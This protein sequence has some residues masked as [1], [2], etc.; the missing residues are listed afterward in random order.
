MKNRSLLIRT[1]LTAMAALMMTAM[2][3]TTCDN[4][5]GGGGGSN[6]GSLYNTYW[7]YKSDAEY[8]IAMF[9]TKKNRQGSLYDCVHITRYVFNDRYTYGFDSDGHFWAAYSVSGNTITI[10]DEGTATRSGDTIEVHRYSGERYTLKK[11]TNF[12][13]DSALQGTWYASYMGDMVTIANGTIDR[14]HDQED[15]VTGNVIGTYR[16]TT[17]CWTTSWGGFFIMPDY[18]DLQSH[19]EGGLYRVDNDGFSMDSYNF[20]KNKP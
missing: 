17:P 16:F 6:S 7:E 15:P 20:Y 1:A 2:V 19:I 5:T 13:V 3:L 4:P 11:R 8:I 12:T 10:E 9:G 14:P 18:R